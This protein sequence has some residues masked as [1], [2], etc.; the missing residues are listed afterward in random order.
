M[1]FAADWLPASETFVYDLVRNLRRRGV[2]V[3]ANPLENSD[4]FPLQDVHSLSAIEHFLHPRAL[5]PAAT[6][7]ALRLIA[8]RRHVGLV[9]VHH[10]YRLEQVLGLVRSRHLPLVLSLHGHDVT[11]YLDEHPDAYRAALPLVSVVLVPSTF[12]VE[13]AVAAGFDRGSVRVLPSGVD[14]EFFSP[15]PLPHGPPTA[16]FVGR[17][18]QKKGLDV[19]AEAWPKVQA[20]LPEARLR[21]L[22]FGPLEHLARAIPGPVSVELAP[23]RAAV[24]AAIRSSHV[25]VSPSKQAVGDAFESLLI[26]N[27]EAQASG[28]PVVTTR[29]GGIPEFVRDGVTAV[30]VPEDDATAL[31]SALIDVL[32]NATLAERMGASGPAWAEQFSLLRTAGRVDRVYDELLETPSAAGDLSSPDR[33]PRPRGAGADAG[34]RTWAGTPDAK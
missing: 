23:T 13:Y 5:R 30:V 32:G 27:L 25:V 28:R 12:L 19:L 18:V 16:V 10:G 2:V 11:G 3:A 26:V 29:H 24:R 31:V 7:A 1:H 21:V 4:R 14:T 20:A 33:R 34:R 17:F 9:H 6:T 15:T 8:G 22:G